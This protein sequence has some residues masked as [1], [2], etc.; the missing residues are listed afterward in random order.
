MIIGID[1]SNIKN[2]G[3]L[4]HLIEFLSHVEPQ[5]FGVNK[6]VIFGGH[7]LDELPNASWL[8]KRKEKLLIQNSFIKESFWKIFKAEKEFISNCNIVF[9]PG[10][11]FHSN[12]IPYVS[13]SQ[14]MLVFE[15]KEAD[16]FGLSWTRLRFYILNILQQKSFN[17][18][19]GVI[20]ISHYAQ[21]YIMSLS[22]ASIK[23][24]TIA[25]FGSSNSFKCPVKLQENISFY[26]PDNPYKI[27]Y[28]SILNSY[29]HQD[30]L[31][32]AVD[33][34]KKKGYPIELLLVGPTYLPFYKKFRT[35]LSKIN[36]HESFIKYLGQITYSEVSKIY[37]ESDLF[38]FPSSC[39]NMPNILIEAMSAGLPIACS[40]Y[41]PMPEFLKDAGEY[42]DPLDIDSM[43]DAIEKLILNPELRYRNAQKAYNYTQELS[44][45]KCANETM[46]FIVSC[47][48]NNN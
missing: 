43:A 7:Q 37:K 24:S 38:V 45:E 31:A 27:L 11:T 28:V 2:S 30:K 46:E 5:K 17:G 15:K 16:R 3:G 32:I 12:K 40:N 29:K 8:E 36:N 41:G 1:A 23:K 20:F 14:N 26:S 42:F 9:A 33:I 47:Y 18:S 44:W 13:M 6:I 22:R 19:Q 21:K 34:L 10:G 25:Y 48:Q 35:T 4:K 39:E